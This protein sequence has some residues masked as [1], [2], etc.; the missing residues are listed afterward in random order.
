MTL[1]EKVII[2]YKIGVCTDYRDFCCTY[3][4]RF[5]DTADPKSKALPS[6]DIQRALSVTPPAG[7]DA[8]QSLMAF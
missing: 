5:K 2:Q 6:I 1:S 8:L 7:F 3:H 4:S